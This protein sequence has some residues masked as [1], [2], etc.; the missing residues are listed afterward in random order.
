MLKTTYK[1]PTPSPLP[2]GWTEHKAPTGHLYYYNAQTKQSTY[3]RPT[4]PTAEIPS[5]HAAQDGLSDTSAAFIGGTPFL[6]VGPQPSA[7][8]RQSGDFRG[9]KSYQNRRRRQDNDRP[10]SKQAIPG[11]EPWIL[12]KTRYGRR[13]IYNPIQNESFWKFPQDVLLAV[14]KLDEA[15]RLR[16]ERGEPESKMKKNPNHDDADE[17]ASTPAQDPL[18]DDHVDSDSYE[19]VEVTDEEDENMKSD[20][21]RLRLDENNGHNSMDFDE[22][23]IEYQ[24]AAMGEDYG[25]ESE[26][27]GEEGDGDGGLSEEDR[28]ALFRDLLDDFHINPYTTW[29]K[30]VEE[31]RIIEDD[32]YVLLPNMHFRRDV[33][34]SWSND[35]IR[36]IKERRLKEEKKDPKIAYVRFLAEHATPKLYWPE[37]KRKFKKEPEMKDTK[38]DDKTREKLYRD[39]IARLKL[40]GS[41]RQ[42]D[43]TDLLKPIPLHS[44]NKSST[45]A[46]L[47]PAIV[48]DLRFISLPAKTRD[49]LV[50]AYISTL[51]PAP[52]VGPGTM[53]AEEQALLDKN[54]AEREKRENAMAQRERLVQQEKQRQRGALRHGRELLKEGEMEIEEAMRVRKDGLRAYVPEEPIN[55]QT[56]S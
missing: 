35:R 16:K 8:S 37:F 48:T 51:P 20:A 55:T 13:F 38:L 33:F 15:E 32:R 52:E 27:Y 18:P 12:V 56:E 31:G 34:H 42:T 43:L 4:A 6:G 9:G 21:K 5:N 3:N 23:D 39:H 46:T 26:E 40:P 36:E 7:N 17:V 53:S 45:I 50:E 2:P 19:E 24:L 54:R 25:L 1:A 28:I 41:T 14:I 49:S 11:V 47:P 44:L 22:D 29:E 10:K 30:V